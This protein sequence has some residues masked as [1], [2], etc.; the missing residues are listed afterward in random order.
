MWE[1]GVDVK[2]IS[3]VLSWHDTCPMV[4][5]DGGIGG[6]EEGAG[7]KEKKSFDNGFQKLR[8]MMII[9]DDA[10]KESSKIDQRW[11]SSGKIYGWICSFGNL[12]LSKLGNFELDT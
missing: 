5:D 2:Q 4:K 1:N 10:K 12:K 3:I 8:L 9:V 6:Y 7:G 11:V